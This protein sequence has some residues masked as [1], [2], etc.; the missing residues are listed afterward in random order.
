MSPMRSG[1]RELG[2]DLVSLKEKLSR[3]PKKLSTSGKNKY[4]GIRYIFKML[5]EEGLEQHRNEMM[6]KFAQI[7]Q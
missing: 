3:M 4:D 7:L 5:L 6:E 1:Y 2:L